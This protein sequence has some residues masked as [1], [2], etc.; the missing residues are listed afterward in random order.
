MYFII[1]TSGPLKL[2]TLYAKTQ[3]Y[4]KCLYVTLVRTSSLLYVIKL[5]MY[6]ALF[7]YTCIATPR[8]ILFMH[9]LL[10]HSECDT[11][12]CFSLQAPNCHTLFTLPVCGGH[13]PPK[14]ADCSSVRDVHCSTVHCQG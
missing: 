5:I 3:V 7:L 6:I 14:C 1:S 2:S 4:G 12:H 10:T 11:L 13:H 8:R 9:Q